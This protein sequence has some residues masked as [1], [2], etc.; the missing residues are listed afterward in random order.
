MLKLS[1]YFYTRA[2]IHRYTQCLTSWKSQKHIQ[3]ATLIGPSLIFLE[4]W[5]F[6]NIEAYICFPPQN[7][8]IKYVSNLYIWKLYCGQCIWDKIEVQLETSW[9][10]ILGTW[11]TFWKTLGNL[12]GRGEKGKS[13]FPKEKNWPSKCM[14]NL[15]IGCMQFL[16]TKLFVTI[17]DMNWNPTIN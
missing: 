6:H 11:G 16:C 9:E 3:K 10:N 12:M 7:R 8:N 1:L 14:L 15:F 4:H 2:H 5:A 13:F 17:F